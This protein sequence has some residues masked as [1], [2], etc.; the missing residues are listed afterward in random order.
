MLIFYV[1]KKEV[2]NDPLHKSGIRWHGFGDSHE[3]ADNI[4]PEYLSHPDVWA[5]ED[6]FNRLVQDVDVKNV[7]LSSVEPIDV[8][9]Q[10][11]SE[12]TSEPEK[13]ATTVDNARIE[14]VQGA[15]MSLDINNPDVLT[16]RKTPKVDLVREAASDDSIT[17][18][19][20]KQAWAA[21]SGND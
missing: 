9:S 12:L 15:I 11:E 14:A 3:I 7:D 10:P 6:G 18:D 21:L 17:A 1:G 16:A 19:E 4:A 20:V 13:P 8:K 2:K 5:D